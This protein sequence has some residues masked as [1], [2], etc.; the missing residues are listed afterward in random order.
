MGGLHAVGSN[1]RKTGST[2]KRQRNILPSAN[3][4][5]AA[6]NASTGLRR[7]GG[8][9]LHMEILVMAL[10]GVALA[11]VAALACY[12]FFSGPAKG[13]PAAVFPTET[14]ERIGR[15]AGL[16]GASIAHAAVAK[17]ALERTYA[18]KPGVPTDA[19]IAMA[20]TLAKA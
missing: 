14:V 2:V 12:L 19:E 4:V 9:G 7:C 17:F 18:G 6:A 5:A 3:P 16:L 13:P 20:V 1:E 10:Q 11:A 8:W 15:I